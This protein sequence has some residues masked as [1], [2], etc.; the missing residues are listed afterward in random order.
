MKKTLVM[1]ITTILLILLT[2]LCFVACSDNDGIFTAFSAE[3]E[4]GTVSYFWKCNGADKFN[5][6]KS[7]S[8]DGEYAFV[9]TCKTNAYETDD[10]KSFYKIASVKNDIEVDLTKPFSYLLSYFGD[11]TKVFTPEDDQKEIQSFIDEYYSVSAW[12]QQGSDRLS[13][14]FMPGVYD[15]VDMHIGYYTTVSGLGYSPSDVTLKAL[16]TFDHP[17]NKDNKGVNTALSNFWRAA[18][19]LTLN[20]NSLW[21]VCQATSLRRIHA[22]K[23]LDLAGYSWSSGGYIAD[24]RIDGTVYA[25]SQQQWFTR[26]SYVN[27]WEG[28]NINMVYAGVQGTLPGPWSAASR[29]VTTLDTTAVTREKPY[30]VF[31]KNEGYGVFLPDFRYNAAGNSWDKEDSTGEFIGINKFYVAESS[32]DTADSINKALEEGKNL[33]LTPGIYELDK[34]IQ[35]KNPDTLVMGMGLATLQLL[36]SNT[37]T[38][39]MISDVDGVNVSGILFKSGRCSD[40]MLV[41]GEEGA[42]QRHENNPICLADLFFCSGAFKY[43]STNVDR[44]LVINSNDVLSDHFWLWRA[45]HG[46]DPGDRSMRLSWTDDWDYNT[47]KNW[48]WIY[49]GNTLFGEDGKWL[50]KSAGGR[51]DNVGRVGLEVNGDYVSIYAL[52]VEH[53]QEYQ[54]IWNG[55]NG[56]MCFYQ[57]ETPYEMETQDLWMRNNG[58]APEDRGWAAYKVA[59]DVQNHEAYGIGIY[60]VK[61]D[62]KYAVTMDHAIEAP[63][64][65]GIKL[66]HMITAKLGSSH[67]SDNIQYIINDR[68]D[69]VTSS[70]VRAGFTSFIGGVYT[71]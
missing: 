14:L 34:P 27:K 49:E 5:V 25:R 58:T 41:V 24:S 51:E 60:M 65:L 35:V 7:D 32:K 17:T 19:N 61:S 69:S 10:V 21:S 57:S 4:H 3:Y 39:L 38:A 18:E 44:T 55:E 30:I 13:M 20:Q 66:V 48:K 64:N 9:E 31:D 15:E 37:D 52:F 26:N 16:H 23:N 70:K 2:S 29:K 67:A 53:Y 68:G 1:T 62:T 40:S 50:V 47:N 54:T 59:D 46:F 71:P 42:N 63:S 6:Y 12:D 45:D 11:N 8:K 36:E 28:V 43:D 22:K 33:I 56:F